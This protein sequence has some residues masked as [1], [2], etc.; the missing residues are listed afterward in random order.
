MLPQE[1]GEAAAA[2]EQVPFPQTQSPPQSDSSPQ[3]AHDGALWLLPCSASEAGDARFAHLPTR[4]T[5]RPVAAPLETAVD[6]V[7]TPCVHVVHRLNVWRVATS[8]ISFVMQR[9]GECRRKGLRRAL[10]YTRCAWSR[11]GCITLASGGPGRA[12]PPCTIWSIRALQVKVT[13][14]PARR[15]WQGPERR[16][17]RCHP[18][19]MQPSCPGPCPSLARVDIMG[20]AHIDASLYEPAPCRQ[21]R[22]SH[23]EEEA[24]LFVTRCVRTFTIL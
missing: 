17:T 2:D 15:L 13:A 4:R 1:T 21:Q 3:S 18:R 7:V 24:V 5:I 20:V 23:K 10:G 19:V 11:R 16:A 22:R 8:A 12:L 6:A 9:G 14:T